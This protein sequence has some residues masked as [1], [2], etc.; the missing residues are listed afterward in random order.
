MCIN[1]N[2]VESVIRVRLI[3]WGFKFIVDVFCSHRTY[4][5]W[6]GTGVY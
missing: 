5:P 6:K 3:L 4:H 2:L 1:V